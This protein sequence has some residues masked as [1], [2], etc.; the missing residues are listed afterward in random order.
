M[1]TCIVLNLKVTIFDVDERPVPYCKTGEIRNMLQAEF[2][3]IQINE[4]QKNIDEITCIFQKVIFSLVK[5][6]KSVISLVK[7][8]TFWMTPAFFP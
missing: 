6:I 8:I 2:Y 4:I 7:N 5:N 3:Y 1:G